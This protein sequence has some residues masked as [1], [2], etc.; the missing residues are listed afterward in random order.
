MTLTS[1]DTTTF[2]V[3]GE[4]VAVRSD[5]DWP[6]IYPLPVDQDRI[7]RILGRVS[8]DLEELARARA[9][10]EVR[11]ASDESRRGEATSPVRRTGHPPAVG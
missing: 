11:F 10:A 6:D 1:T 5:H 8:A 9:L 7:M 2:T 4:D 3:N